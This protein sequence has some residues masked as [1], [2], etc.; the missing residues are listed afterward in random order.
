MVLG[1]ACR[2]HLAAPPHALLRAAAARVLACVPPCARPGARA[3]AT[4]PGQSNLPM[5]IPQ[6]EEP[7]EEEEQ[8]VWNRPT[9]KKPRP[10]YKSPVMYLLA[11]VPITTFFLGRWQIRR[12]HW[13]VNLIDEIDDKLRRPPLHLPKN[14]NMD[15]LPEF[16]YRLVELRGRF[17]PS[18]TMFLGPRS[19]DG[20][21]GYQVVMPFRRAGGGDD[22]L[23]NRGFVSLR[24]VLGER[25]GKHLRVP[26]TDGVNED[27]TIQT[28]MPR[29]SPPTWSTIPNAPQ[30]N[31]W[32]L[33]NPKE[34]ADYLNT[35]PGPTV[36]LASL[37]SAGAQ[38]APATSWRERLGLG[39]E[40]AST[41][42]QRPVLPIFLD[43]VFDGT[44]LQASIRVK[45]GVPVGRPPQIELRNQHAEYAITWYVDPA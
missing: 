18:R 28:L 40:S 39:A 23:V 37:A 9:R 31:H 5:N 26:I 17:D 10:W 7:P 35:H 30:D 36:P 22:V 27:V 6:P 8:V 25:N 4:Q 34:M 29:I 38:G 1:S 42:E 14:I 32:M 21:Q 16:E 11:A 41:A 19:R 12:L 44:P 20:E 3:L 24:N 45:S 13:K 15:V 2:R 33:Q 43:E